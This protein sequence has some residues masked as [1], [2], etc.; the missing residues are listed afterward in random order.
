MIE[1]YRGVDQITVVGHAPR[2]EGTA[3]GQN[4]VCAAVSAL[5]LTLVAGLEEVADMRLTGKV[6]EEG[7]VL[8]KWKAATPL[9]K[10]L[11]KTWFIGIN[12]IR[13]NYPG[14]ILII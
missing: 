1:V 10:A 4:I 14:T 3:P 13:D 6:V 11:I 8:L 7:R 2:P 5:T 9:G 12:Q